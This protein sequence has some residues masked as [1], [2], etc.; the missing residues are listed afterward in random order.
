MAPAIGPD[1]AV[2]AGGAPFGKDVLQEIEIVRRVD[3]LDGRAVVGGGF[4][5]RAETDLLDAPENDFGALRLLEG[6]DDAAEGQFHAAVMQV[7][8]GGIEG[9]HDQTTSP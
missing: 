5:H 4:D 1:L 9:F 2:A 3:T 6:L 8:V 7:M